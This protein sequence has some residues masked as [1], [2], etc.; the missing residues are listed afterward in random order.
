MDLLGFFKGKIRFVK[1]KNMFKPLK[2]P[3]P[4]RIPRFRIGCGPALCGPRA[5]GRPLAAARDPARGCAARHCEG[6][7][8]ARERSGGPHRI[9]AD[10]LRPHP[11]VALRAQNNSRGFNG[12]PRCLTECP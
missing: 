4:H 1:I 10:Q 2:L 9:L 12:G 8:V 3:Q 7:R 6:R 11:H 5:A